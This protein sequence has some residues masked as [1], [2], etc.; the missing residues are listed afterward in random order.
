[1][2]DFTFSE[3]QT[4][5]AAALRR[6]LEG[7]CASAELRRVYDAVDSAGESRWRRLGEL[8]L[9]AVLAAESH[10]G[11]DLAATD[12]VLLAEEAGRAALPE[13]LSEHA[14]IAVPALRELAAPETVQR[15]AADGSAAIAIGHSQNP[16]AQLPPRPAHWLLFEP[17]G[18]YLYDAEQVSIAAVHSVDAGRRLCHPQP[19]RGAGRRMASGEVAQQ[20]SA[21]AFERGALYAAAQCLGLTERLLGL[22]IGYAR[23]RRQF[24]R[25]IGANQAI[26]HQLA[27]VQVKLEF[28][29]PV[30]YAAA[31]RLA[32]ADARSLVAVSHAK[33]AAADAAELAAR[34]AIQVHGAMGYSWEVDVHFYM[35]R[36]WALGGAWGARSYHARRLQSLLTSGALTLG[37]DTTFADGLEQPEEVRDEP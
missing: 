8:G 28:A 32:R 12:F 31:A 29:R 22:A 16:Y 20:A 7:I 36:A 9:F 33:I 13:P 10:G 17:D 15:S 25:A 1:M 3:Q 14:G 19:R 11:M 30:V 6:L 35:K 37:P 24:G 5:M 27:N 21:R 34:T 23:E 4:E 26:K 2:M 18:V